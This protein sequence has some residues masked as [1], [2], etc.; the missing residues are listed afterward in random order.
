MKKNKK[1]IKII[2]SVILFVLLIGG[3][4]IWFLVNKVF[5]VVWNVVYDLVCGDKFDLWDKVV[6]FI[7]NNVF[8]LIMG[9]DESDVWGKEYGEVIRIDVFLFVIFNKDSKIVKL[10]SILCDIYI[11]ILIEKKK[12][13]IIYVYV[14]G[15]VKNGKNGGL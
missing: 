7:I 12:D 5:F 13:K 3:G 1:K 15:F 6:K 14:F 2:I 11:Y 8:V 9:V 10:L 4:Y